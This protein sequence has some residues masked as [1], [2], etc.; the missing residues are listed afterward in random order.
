MT[1]LS[2]QDPT[3]TE[4]A[5][6]SM[7]PID[8]ALATWAARVRADRE[9]VHRLREVEDPSDFYAPVAARFRMDPRRTGDATLDELRLL[10]RP[11]ETWLDIGAGGGRFALPIA[12]L[13]REVIAVE[14][15]RGMIDVLR[16][17][18]RENAIGNIQVIEGHW[19]VADPPNVDVSLMAHVGYDIEAIGSFLDA[20]EAASRRLCVAVMGQTAM[21]TV[22]TLYWQPIYGEPRAMLPAL[23]ELVALLIARGES[24]TVRLV[25]RIAPT[26]DSFE[27]LVAAARRQLWL[28][29]GSER[30][31]KLEPLLRAAAREVNGRW[32]LPEEEARI[33][34]V[35]W[36]A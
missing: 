19:P 21:T 18:M 5:A 33:G 32:Q 6:A 7:P 16:E 15:S 24:P 20:M 8:L 3:E 14:P 34:V 13:T 1:P 35:T 29:P 23:P 9:Q 12:L 30:D 26:F 22:A 28:K 4:V 10:A 27:A 11:T 2:D 25:E 17:G 31:Q 36:T